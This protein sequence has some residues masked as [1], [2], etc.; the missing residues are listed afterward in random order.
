[1]SRDI[2]SKAHGHTD[3]IIHAKDKSNLARSG[4]R[5]MVALLAGVK[6]QLACEEEV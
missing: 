1:M 5:Q 4:D 2:L 6:D 3:I